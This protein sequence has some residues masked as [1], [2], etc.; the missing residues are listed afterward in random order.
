MTDTSI[1]RSSW[2]YVDDP[3]YK[4]V[5]TLVTGFVDRLSKNGNTLLNVGPRPDGSIPAAAERRLRSF[6]DWLRVN[7][8][9]VFESRPWWTF[10]EGPTEV[11]STEFEEASSVEFTGADVRFT[12]SADGRVGYAIVMDWPENGEL[13]LG[14]SLHHRLTGRNRA[15]EVV[16]PES[17]DLLGTDLDISWDVDEEE[18]VLRISLPDTPPAALDNAYTLRLTPP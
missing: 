6:G 7:D 5:D 17:I 8:E 12:R 10:G 3:E 11:T 18:N 9:A 2:G 4:D 1:D 13:S 15:D 14:T 16:A